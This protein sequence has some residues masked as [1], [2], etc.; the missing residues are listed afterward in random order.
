MD[1]IEESQTA[2]E[3]GRSRFNRM[4]ERIERGEGNAI[5][6]WDIDRLYR[7]P[8]DEGRVRWMLQKGI[9]AAVFKK[10]DPHIF[11]LRT[12]DC[13][14]RFDGGRASDFIIHHIRN[15]TR[16]R[17]KAYCVG[18]GQGKGRSDTFTT[19]IYAI[20]FPTPRRQNRG[21]DL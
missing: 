4:L 14:W 2:K 10:P 6:I 8:V 16:S 7:N 18:N 20:S 12:L 19:M 1:I 9:I 11:S 21:Y 5:L 15:V 17:G 3:P 13:S